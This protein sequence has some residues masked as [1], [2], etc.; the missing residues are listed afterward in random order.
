MIR[1]LLA[2]LALTFALALG[3]AAQPTEL[4]VELDRVQLALLEIQAEVNRLLAKIERIQMAIARG[5]C[6]T[7]RLKVVV[8]EG[9]AD[10][11]TKTGRAEP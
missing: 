7:G 6:S 4:V 10:G 8:C 5:E 2:A 3:A 9:P 1:P 11:A